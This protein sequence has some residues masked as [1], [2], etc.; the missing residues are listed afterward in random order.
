MTKK[1][2]IALANSI[3]SAKCTEHSFNDCQIAVIADFCRAQ[4][5]Q[6]NRER[7]IG[8]INGTN[9]PSGGRVKI[10]NDGIVNLGGR[11]K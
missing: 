5:P 7:W 11:A 6:F 3:K 4:N 9:G 8:Y 10:E 2:F 1:H